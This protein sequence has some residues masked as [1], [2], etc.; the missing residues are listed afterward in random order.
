MCFVP[1][2]SIPEPPPLPPTPSAPPAPSSAA[3]SPE[4]LQSSST[5]SGLRLR[6]SRREASGDVARGTG[7]L[8][9]PMNTGQAKS[10][11]LNY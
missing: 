3:P 1:T 6:R 2:P 4:P 5:Q 10:G 7:Q 11:G 8:R 9:I